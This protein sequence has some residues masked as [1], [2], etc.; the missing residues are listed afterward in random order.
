MNFLVSHE[1]AHLYRRHDGAVSGIWTE[2]LLESARGSIESQ[3]QELD[4][5]GYACYLVLTHL[6]R[7]ERRQSALQQLNR[8]DTVRGDADEALLT[9]FFLAV[10][11]FFCSL[12]RGVSNTASLYQSPH[13]PPPVRITHAIRVAEMW[14]SQNESVLFDA[15]RFRV[16]FGAA[17]EIIEGTAKQTWDAEIAFLRSPE[18]ADYDRQLF[19]RFEE[20]RQKRDEPKLSN[21]D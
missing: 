6:L 21:G 11:A 8:A 5:D 3:A 12:W 20:M 13:P 10:L 19:E 2:F 9:S 17:T 4:A 16:L 7:G 15:A 18:G 14:C 1:F